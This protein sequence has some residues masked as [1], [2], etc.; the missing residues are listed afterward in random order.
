M[1]L[2]G[3]HV[4]KDLSIARHYFTLAADNGHAEAAKIL[5]NPPRF[6]ARFGAVTLLSNVDLKLMFNR[7]FRTAAF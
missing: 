7:I 1:Y 3:V 4:E 2:K 5:K 6:F